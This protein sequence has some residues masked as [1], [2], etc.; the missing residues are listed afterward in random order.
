MNATTVIRTPLTKT[1]RQRMASLPVALPT[2]EPV[3]PAEGLLRAEWALE[4]SGLRCR[5]RSEDELLYAYRALRVHTGLHP[6]DLG[7]CYR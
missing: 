7:D 1:D 5:V 3:N 6:A 4:R 2:R